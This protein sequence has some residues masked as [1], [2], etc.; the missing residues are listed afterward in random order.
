MSI[1]KQIVFSSPK[2]TTTTKTNQ[3]QLTVY[4]NFVAIVSFLFFSLFLPKIVSKKLFHKKMKSQSYNKKLKVI[5]G[6]T[7]V[8]QITFCREQM[9]IN[10][11]SDLPITDEKKCILSF[12]IGSSQRQHHSNISL[13]SGFRQHNINL[14]F[15]VKIFA[16]LYEA[17]RFNL[18]TLLN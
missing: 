3:L 16:F 6:W 8:Y 13:A 10:P 1:W 4:D 15:Y 12:R 18:Q 9:K 5:I 14:N 7:L 17:E 11:E 2:K